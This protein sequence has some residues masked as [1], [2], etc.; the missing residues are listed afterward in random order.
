MLKKTNHM[1]FTTWKPFYK[2]IVADFNFSITD[3]ERAASLLNVLLKKKSSAIN[4]LKDLIDCKDM[5]IFG[6]GPSLESSIIK[7]KNRFANSVIITADGATSAL[8][9]HNISPDVI[10]TDL[11][12]NIADQRQANSE[13]SV[14]VVHAHG[15]NIEQIKKEVPNFKGSLVGTTQ[16][17]PR[18]YSRLYNFGGFTDG[19]RA[20]YLA[21]YFHAKSIWLVGFDFTDEIGIYS[22]AEYKNKDVKLKKLQWCKKLLDALQKY[23]PN[24][25][26]L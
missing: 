17:D 10:V 12:G 8:M 25:H 2:K 11:D 16:T 26:Y 6:A 18:P 14:V 23:N 20:A 22:F 7:H 15:D 9:K 3:D 5:F 19:D 21:D 1:N 4:K 24:V 13:G